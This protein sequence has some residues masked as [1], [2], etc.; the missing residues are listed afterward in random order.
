LCGFYLGFNSF[1]LNLFTITVGMIFLVLKLLDLMCQLLVISSLHRN[2]HQLAFWTWKHIITQRDLYY[3]TP[4]CWTTCCTKVR[5]G[6]QAPISILHC[7]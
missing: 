2:T 6:R 7:W 1:D 4:I 3:L 5:G